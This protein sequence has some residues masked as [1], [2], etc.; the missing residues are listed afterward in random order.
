[1]L[2]FWNSLNR[3]NR[4]PYAVMNPTKPLTG[5]PYKGM[6]YSRR[7][8]SGSRI[9]H[10]ACGTCMG[11]GSC[12]WAWCFS[13]GSRHLHLGEHSSNWSS[14]SS[15]IFVPAEFCVQHAQRSPAEFSGYHHSPKPSWRSWGEVGGCL[16]WFLASG[17]SFNPALLR[18]VVQEGHCKE[19]RRWGKWAWWEAQC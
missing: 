17:S 14:V 16:S 18:L 10:H 4:L 11:P 6:D 13:R 9:D 19:R 5:V 1:M 8:N 12:C 2:I 7:T 3:M 15:S